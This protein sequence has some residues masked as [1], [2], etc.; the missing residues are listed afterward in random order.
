MH[1]VGSDLAVYDLQVLS[2]LK[3]LAKTRRE[4]LPLAKHN[5]DELLCI[6]TRWVL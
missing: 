6:G 3:P 5:V 2:I 1:R 4:D